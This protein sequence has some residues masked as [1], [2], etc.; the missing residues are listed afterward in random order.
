VRGKE[1][2]IA[3][4]CALLGAAVA[5]AARLALGSWPSPVIYYSLVIVGLGAALVTV[6]YGRLGPF[7]GEFGAPSLEAQVRED[8]LRESD[9]AVRYGR[10]L[11]IV[12]VRQTGGAPVLW[13]SA[14]RRVDDVFECR[15]GLFVLLLPETSSEGALNLLRRVREL[16]SATLEGAM[17][18]CPNDGRTGDEISAQ[19]L[20]L[21]REARRPNEVIVRLNGSIESLPLT[22]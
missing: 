18:V 4:A 22:F 11:T 17:V 16:Y 13:T 10:E 9:R 5:Y 21:I 8:I 14:V 3:V 1:V 2:L 7:E 19:L 6:R 15:R 12:A 20:S